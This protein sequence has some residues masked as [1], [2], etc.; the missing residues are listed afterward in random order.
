MFLNGAFGGSRRGMELIL[1]SREVQQ[2]DVSVL[3]KVQGAVADGFKVRD[4]PCKLMVVQGT[5]QEADWKALNVLPRGS[6]QVKAVLK[7][8][9]VGYRSSGAQDGKVCVKPLSV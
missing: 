9:Q 1:A 8:V 4:G 2:G 7:V 6:L 5:I 3:V